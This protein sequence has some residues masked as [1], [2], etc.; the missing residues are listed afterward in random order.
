MNNFLEAKNFEEYLRFSFDS[1]TKGAPDFLKKAMEYSLFSGGKRIRPVLFL[2]TYELFCPIDET[3][4]SFACAIEVFHTFTLIHDD[5]PCMDNDDFRRGIPTNHKVFGEAQA[6]LAGDSLQNL[7]YTYLIDAVKKSGYNPFAIKAMERFNLC[8]GASGVMGGQSVDI[9]PSKSVDLSTVEFVYKHKTC[10]LISASMEC[11]S[12]L[13]GAT[14]S[15]IEN[16]SK[17]AYRFGYVFQVVDD[18]LDEEKSKQEKSILNIFDKDAVLALI[19][20]L[21]AEA[22]ENIEKLGKNVDFF[23]DLIIKSKTRSK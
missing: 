13:A 17:Y 8:A 5:L 7:A 12:I 22:I 14:E 20:K 10:D 15:D 2:K 18:L 11:A 9:E 4:L 21:T 1:F 6:V 3:A 16:V 23:K 19:D